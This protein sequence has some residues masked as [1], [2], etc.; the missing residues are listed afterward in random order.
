MFRVIAF[1]QSVPV[2]SDYTQSTSASPHYWTF[3]VACPFP[4]NPVVSFLID[5]ERQLISLVTRRPAQDPAR[6]ECTSRAGRRA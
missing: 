6:E 1:S 3:E 4:E 5:A 2:Q